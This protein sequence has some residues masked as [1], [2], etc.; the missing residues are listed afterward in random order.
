MND[1]NTRARAKEIID[2]A[3]NSIF[4][5][6][7][8]NNAP[9]S[10]TMWTAG[11]DDDFTTYY[12]THRDMLKC[13]QIKNNPKVCSF[14]T[15]V[16]GSTIGWSYVMLKGEAS[17][18][19]EQPMRDRFWN[20][21]LTEYFKSKDDPTFVIIVVRPKELLMMDANQYPLKRIEF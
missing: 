17:I 19:D 6:V 16:E 15:M 11:T 14:W 18:T 2:A 8:E 9:H 10:R 4:T 3:V 5:T 21:A 1:N 13:K 12:V 7:D 20:E